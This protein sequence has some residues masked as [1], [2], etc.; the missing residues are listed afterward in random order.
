[1]ALAALQVGNIGSSIRVTVRDQDNTVV[2]LSTTSTRTI[3]LRDPTGKV[4]SKSGT[5]VSG[6]TT[7]IMEY[8]TISGDLAIPGEW[9]IQARFVNSGGTFYT[10]VDTL[11]VMQNL[12]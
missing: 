3:F 8:V 10:N 4:L 2:D 12:A 6:G 5:L 7:G 1:M 9:A 11:P